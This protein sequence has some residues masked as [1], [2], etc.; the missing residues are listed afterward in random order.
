[1]YCKLI[2]TMKCLGFVFVQQVWRVFS[3]ALIAEAIAKVS[4]TRIRRFS[5]QNKFLYPCF[6]DGMRKINENTPSSR[7]STFSNLRK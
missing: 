4:F 7:K 5:G 1:M 2:Y 3:L 6:L